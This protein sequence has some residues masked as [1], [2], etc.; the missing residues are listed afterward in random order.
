MRQLFPLTL[1][2]SGV[3][4]AGAPASRAVD[5]VAATSKPAAMAE[6]KPAAPANPLSFFD[7]RLV[8]DVQERLRLEYRDNNVTFNDNQPGDE[9]FWLLHR[10]RAGVLGQP[11]DWLKLYGQM[12]DS[13]EMGS[14]RFP[15]PPLGNANL[16]EDT[17][18]WRQAWIELGNYKEFP[19]SF[20]IG[21]QELA[22]GDERL[23]GTFDWNNVG[24]T[25]D[26]AR[27]RW[28][29][30]K[31]WVDLF[32]ANVVGNNIAYGRDD[33]LND[34]ADWADDL[35]G[36]YGQCSA[37]D[38]QIM[39]LYGI[40]RD[41]TEATFD[42]PAREIWTFG[43]RIKSTPKLGPWD[44]Y[45][46]AAY[47]IGHIDGPGLSATQGVARRFGE[48][49]LKLRIPHQA[50]A[51]LVGVGY[52]VPEVDWKPRV[53]FEY[54]YAT[55]DSDPADGRN[56]TFDNLFPTNHKFYGYMDFFAWKN[57]HNP[58]LMFTTQPAKTVTTQLD[59]HMFWLAEEK[60]LWYRANSA[61]IG[62]P[63]RRNV[64]GNASSFVGSEVDLSATWAVT[65]NIKVLGG[66]SHFFRGGY[67]R[68]TAA[69]L[70]NGSDDA[71]LVYLQTMV[72]F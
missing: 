3:L 21:R 72:S 63:A 22:Y 58:R 43:A 59:F 56:E 39:E 5:A 70:N 1:V 65:K 53:G 16:E 52:T 51:A 30:G 19:V 67:V 24:R 25:F 20:K 69:G 37:L 57:V 28:Q 26:A 45:M 23:V 49:S 27:L 8:F 41:K 35:F 29:G 48:N 62:V 10:F 7:G 71:E 50:L 55:G 46:E 33:S 44:Y 60:D 47:Q 12:Q 15:A 14:E 54:N 17:V 36:I 40:L 18:D 11:L 38:F 6:A 9:D 34:V 42:G 31:F 61:P 4:I 68:D 2:L 13:R 64:V 66:Y 32:A